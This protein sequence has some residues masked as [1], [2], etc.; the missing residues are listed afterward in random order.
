MCRFDAVTLPENHN[1]D[2]GET[3]QSLKFSNATMEFQRTEYFAM[4]NISIL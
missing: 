4:V 3:E 2:V 1:I